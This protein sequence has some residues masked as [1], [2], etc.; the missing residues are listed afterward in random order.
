MSF[1]GELFTLSGFCKEFMPDDKRTKSNTYRGCAFFFKDGV[2]LEKLFKEQQKKSLVSSKEEIAAVPD[3][4][5][6]LQNTINAQVKFYLENVC[7]ILGEDGKPRR[8]NVIKYLKETDEFVV[9]CMDIHNKPTWIGRKVLNIIAQCCGIV[10]MIVLLFFYQGKRRLKL[11][12]SLLYRFTWNM[13]LMRMSPFSILLSKVS[14]ALMEM[15]APVTFSCISCMRS[16]KGELPKKASLVEIVS[17][18]VPSLVL[19]Y[20]V[21]F[22]SIS[23]MWSR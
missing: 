8:W 17:V 7:Y 5:D 21:T 15:S 9:E 23:F 16:L 10:I 20:R 22:S 14:G 3:D 4:N 18:R 19:T 6:S 12:T 11:N 1:C 13:S 2:K